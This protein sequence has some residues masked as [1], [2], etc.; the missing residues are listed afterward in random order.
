MK[1]TNFPL[2]RPNI[3]SNEKRLQRLWRQD[4]LGWTEIQRWKQQAERISSAKNIEAQNAALARDLRNVF[5]GQANDDTILLQFQQAIIN[6]H[7]FLSWLIG[8]WLPPGMHLP[9]LAEG[10]VSTIQEPV[11]IFS[12]WRECYAQRPSLAKVREFE[13]RRLWNLALLFYELQLS[14]AKYLGEAVLGKITEYLEEAFFVKGENKNVTVISYH[15]PQNKM[16]VKAWHYAGDPA[17]KETEGLVPKETIFSC[18][19]F[20]WR[21]KVHLVDFY[22][23]EKSP[24]SHLLK[25][26]RKNIRDPFSAALDLV[27][28]RFVFFDLDALEA[29]VEKLRNCVFSLPGVAWKMTDNL[30]GDA[31]R[32]N[33]RH[34]APNFYARKYIFLVGGVGCEILI[35]MLPNYLNT[36]RSEGPQNHFLYRA[37]QLLHEVFPL[38]FPYCLYGIK[39]QAK[40]EQEKVYD[41]VKRAKIK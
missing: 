4:P 34:S 17:P 26:L 18:R 37:R 31:Q 5:G 32:K 9:L 11:A 33:N 1:R 21:N 25:M 12:L 29:G 41:L 15:Q 36:H 23:R 39:W 20:A 30:L 27:G 16:L 38:L 22:P 40:E 8:E 7:Q 6:A 19:L 24:F 35:E 14:R 13:L 3:N 28:R 10:R 2:L